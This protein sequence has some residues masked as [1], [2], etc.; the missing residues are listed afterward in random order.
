MLQAPADYRIQQFPS[1][2]Y[3][4]Q[5][6]ELA[7]KLTA[8]IHKLYGRNLKLEERWKLKKLTIILHEKTH[9]ITRDH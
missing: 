1:F 2:N 3:L 9:Q 8:V 7:S 6:Q 5:H 4:R